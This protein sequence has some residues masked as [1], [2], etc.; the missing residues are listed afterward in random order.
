VKERS[1]VQNIQKALPLLRE[2]V[3]RLVNEQRLPSDYDGS[4]LE[5]AENIQVIL[6][7]GG[8]VPVAELIQA[9]QAKLGGAAKKKLKQEFHADPTR[10]Q[11]AATFLTEKQEEVYALARTYAHNYPTDSKNERFY[12]AVWGVEPGPLTLWLVQD[13]TNGLEVNVP[14]S[15]PHRTVSA[16]TYAAATAV[17][18]H[19]GGF[20]DVLVAVV[21]ERLDGVILES[22]G[23]NSA[24]QFDKFHGAR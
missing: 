10:V 3:A 8:G 13:G 17:V 21:G 14:G 19:E 23:P 4:T 5:L 11:C 16:T 20:I 15:G 18:L 1:A 6:G 12:R 22:N 24:I 9:S 7:G 2:M